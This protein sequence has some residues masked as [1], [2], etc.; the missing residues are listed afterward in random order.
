MR[1]GGMGGMELIGSLGVTSRVDVIPWMRT[2][3]LLI[4]VQCVSVPIQHA[5]G[6]SNS[7]KSSGLHNL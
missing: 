5:K 1:D 3:M 7:E 4:Y 2:S 6:N